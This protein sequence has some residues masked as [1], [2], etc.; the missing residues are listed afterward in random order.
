MA[1]YP[2]IDLRTP[3]GRLVMGDLAK[4]N[5]NDMHG[6]PRD[7]PQYFFALAVPK[8]D[9]NVI[10]LI[11]QIMQHAWNSYSQMPDV[12]GR[13]QAGLAAP[14]FAWKI[15]DGDQKHA[16]KQGCAGCWIFK[17]AT[18]LPI[19]AANR[20][21]QQ[22]DPAT[23]ELG[24]YADVAFTV[25]INGNRDRT[26]GIYMNPNCV[27]LLGYGERIVPGPSIDTLMG[28]APAALP[29]GASMTPVAPGSGGAG[30]P[31]QPGSGGAGYPQQPGYAPVPIQAPAPHEGHVQ[32][33]GLAPHGQ[34]GSGYAANPGYPSNH[35][36]APPLP[37]VGNYDANG[38]VAPGYAT[39]AP[40]P[41]MQAPGYPATAYPSN[42][43]GV[44][45]GATPHPQFLHGG[46]Q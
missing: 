27:R 36:P 29:P 17:F 25:A 42:P 10:P 12:T 38:P 21:N 5:P 9:P 2:R 20:E 14:D 16:D 32:Q 19:R 6:K 28:A 43:P 23:I 24:S 1:D 4:P 35:Q 37:P 41:A 31:Q 46:G 45:A 30:Y 44:P 18:T 39:G 15:D 40:A 13:L 33:P 8:S 7:K 22:I 26:A 3:V 34:T 11:N